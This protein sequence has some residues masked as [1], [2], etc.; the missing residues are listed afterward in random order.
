MSLKTWPLSGLLLF[1]NAD[2]VGRAEENGRGRMSRFFVICGFVFLLQ[3]IRN[4][5]T[6]PHFPSPPSS[7]CACVWKA[8]EN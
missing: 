5:F 2:E 4:L 7:L 6:Q 3:E 1:A 8:K